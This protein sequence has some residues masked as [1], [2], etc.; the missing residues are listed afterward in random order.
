[1]PTPNK[2]FDNLKL[3]TN[4]LISTKEVNINSILNDTNINQYKYRLITYLL[5]YPRLI[6]YLNNYINDV[7]LF[8]NPKYTISDWLHTFKLIFK[9][10]NFKSLDRIYFTKFKLPKRSTFKNEVK[11]FELTINNKLLS[12][13]EL[14]ELYRLYNLKIISEEHFNEIKILNSG[15]DT[16]V[17]KIPFDIDLILKEPESIHVVPSISEFN[18]NLTNYIKNRVSCKNCALYSCP[19]YPIISNIKNEKDQLDVIIVGEFPS[20]ENFI[21][22]HRYVKTL[23]DKYDLNYLATNL[24]LCKPTNDEIPNT[25]KTISNCKE[26]TNHIYKNFKS[27]FKIIIGTNSKKFFN[28]KAPMTKVNGELINDYFV[29]ASPNYVSQHKTGLIKL[30]SFLEK[31]SKEKISRLNIETSSIDSTNINFNYDLKNYTLF[32][33]KIINEQVLYILLENET[34]N[35]KYITENIS[36]PVYIKTGNYRQCDH[37]LN[38]TDFVVYLSKSQKMNLS[39]QMKRQLN[40]EV[41][42]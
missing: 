18:N 11:E 34:G 10:N 36:Y 27:N 37:F 15:K 2:S 23:L 29:L 5:K 9:N 21:E 35:K 41:L 12:E 19:K 22:D 6:F 28:I 14:N 31:Y 4:W 39:Q 24:V 25:A 40:K 8:D 30:N 16:K 33:I 3:L 32:D 38:N 26:V 13:N 42:L 1:M 20:K 17:T 7:Y